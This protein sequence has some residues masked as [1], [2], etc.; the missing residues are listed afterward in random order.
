MIVEADVD[1]YHCGEN[2][3]DEHYVHDGHDFCCTGCR[4]VYDLLKE[5]DLCQYYG[6]ADGKGIS[7]QEHI[8]QGKFDHLDF[9][10]IR[11]QLLEFTDGRQERVNWSV[12]GMHCSSCIWLLEQLHRLHPGVGSSVVN[13][14]E[15]TV[16]ISLD[17]TQ[18][19]LSAL[20]TLMARLG[21]EPYL[22]LNDTDHSAIG[23]G[24]HKQVSRKKLY[25]IGVAGFAF[26][27][28]MML[29][30]PEYFNLGQGFEDQQLRLLFS[31][32][33]LAL[34][35]PVF[36]YSA[37]E[38]FISAW[39]ALRGRYLNIDAPIALALISV[40][41]TSLYQLATQSGPG[42]FDSLAGAVFFML[43]GRY[44]QDRTYANIAFDR[45]YKSYFPIA[46]SVMNEGIESRRPVQD[47]QPGDRILV[48][49]RELIPADATLLSPAALIDY[50]FVSGEAD[51]LERRR[52]DLLYAGGR[53]CG[54]AVELE[55]VRRVSQSYLTQLWNNDAFTKKKEDQ[56]KTLASRINRY[57]SAAVLLLAAIT[58]A[59][60]AV[61]NE[62]GTAFNAFTTILLV[63]CPCA[64]L[65][66]STFTNANLLSLFGKHGFYFKNADAI[67][68]LAKTDTVV[69]DKT[70]TVTLPHE[71]E[72]QF[73][74]ETLTHEEKTI[75]KTLA[76]QSSHPLSRLIVKS[77]AEASSSKK[78]F[79]DFEEKEGAG[80]AALWG[81]KEIR[82]GS[83][84]WI[85]NGQRDR[86]SASDPVITSRSLT[87][88][89]LLTQPP[90]VHVSVD[91]DLR[92]H[93][94]IRPKYRPGLPPALTALQ[95][96]GYRTFLLSGDQP[97]DQAFLGG[98]FKN[99]SQLFFEQN[100]GQKLD[101]IARLQ[102][103]KNRHV[104][105]V[106]DGLNDAGALQ[107]SDVGLAVTDDINNFSP[108]C[109]AIVQGEKL[110]LLP[111]YI[112]L[113]RAGQRIIKTS[114]GI[115][116]LY[117]LVGISFAITGRLSPVTAAIL[118]PLSSITIVLFT[119][120]AT[121]LAARRW[122]RT[123]DV[124]AD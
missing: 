62:W 118:M 89:Q 65:L 52:G 7:P 28:I 83:K 51:A 23:G 95:N 71:A 115:S 92:G 70:G 94:D 104:L 10:E 5:N 106:G 57:F 33:N 109:D 97:T 98:L 107:Q 81:R 18:I 26:G 35:L 90:R 22:S 103:E 30:L 4:T 43:L 66:S 121:N 80:L 74:G 86:L 63:A 15:K 123:G 31:G 120:A 110:P 99:E 46:V 17:P 37:S 96:E 50:S 36:L 69:F 114:F 11:A 24:S 60:W 85:S 91:G 19:K 117:N 13:F 77:M 39:K 111:R 3:L 56:N 6:F 47:L 76:A 48:R 16:R 58:F 20:A 78:A 122:L 25:K 79:T 84:K 32:L 45:D 44:F 67:E 82:L 105:M 55:I 119:T 9:E 124:C 64:L 100:P 49:N 116:L 29:S 102:R 61:Q 12:P 2:C 72:V 27:N 73:V 40:F 21:Y 34:A 112:R 59:V 8:F 87:T 38:F 75:V 41:L 1:C 88:K 68:R 108:A 14:P 53:Q 93:F 54:P 101:F 113:A 42:Y